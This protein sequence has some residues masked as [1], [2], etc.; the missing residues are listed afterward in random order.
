MR[1][2]AFGGD[3]VFDEAFF[4]Q[5]DLRFRQIEIDRPAPVTARV[6]DLEQLAHQLEHRHELLRIR[7]SLP[8]PGR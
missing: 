1:D 5:H 2:V 3:D 6:Q 4:V 8:D 7:A